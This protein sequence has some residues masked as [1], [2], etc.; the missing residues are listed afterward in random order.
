M[1]ETGVSEVFA[2]F[3]DGRAYRI[4][5]L[6][7]D[8]EADI[9]VARIVAPPG[10]RFRP[11]PIG[12]S[13][14]MRRGDTVIALGAPLGGSLVPL[15][16]ILGGVRY[17]ADDEIMRAVLRSRSDWCLLQIDCSLSSGNSGGPILDGS[18]KVIGVASLVQNAGP[19]GHGA[20]NFGVS[21]DQAWPVVED[22]LAAGSVRRA[23]VGMSILSVDTFADESSVQATGVRLLP[24]PA[25]VAAFHAPSAAAASPPAAPFHSGLYISAVSPGSP[26]DSAGLREGDVVL[27]VN[28]R[29]MVRKGD[30]FAALGPV[31]RKGTSLQCLVYRP[32]AARGHDGTLFRTTVLPV[33]RRGKS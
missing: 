10:T 8:E 9:A 31:Y 33:P 30:Y 1:L 12:S 11:L 20:L 28:G 19:M 6:A 25:L 32:A 22:L 3:D 17:V 2:H 26:A 21:I 24:P 4:T 5:P 7:S 13:G 27:E 15:V 23:R 14:G 29:R 16:G 18:G